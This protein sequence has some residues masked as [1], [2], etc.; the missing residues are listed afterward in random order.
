MV[1]SKL[2]GRVCMGMYAD[3]VRE[4][5]GAEDSESDSP[6]RERLRGL[7]NDLLTSTLNL[8]EEQSVPARTVPSR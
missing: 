1:L 6:L 8:M 5:V 2:D 4:F 7:A 3:D